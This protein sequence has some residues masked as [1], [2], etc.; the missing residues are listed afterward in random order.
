[1]KSSACARAAA[2]RIC[3]VV[4]SGLPT[5]RFS[6][7]ERLNSSA[8]WNTTPILRRSAASLI[9]RMS[10]PSIVIAPGLRIEGAMQQRQRRRLAGAG[11]ADQ[12]D[13]L[14]RLRDEV[15]I[16]D[17]RRACRR[18]RTR[19]CRTR[20][21]RRRG[22]D[23]RASGRS[24]MRG[25]VSSTSKNSRSR[26]ASMASRLAKPT[27]CSSCDD[28][29]AGERHE[30]DDLADRGQAELE[31]PGAEQDDRQ[32]GER[33]RGA[34]QHRHHRPPR[35]H[36]KLRRQQRSLTDS[37][38]GHFGLDA[39]EALHQRDVA[40]RIGGAFGEVGMICLPRLL[41]SVSVLRSTTAI[42]TENSTHSTSSSMRQPPVDPQRQ[43]Q[44]HDQT[45]RRPR[46]FRGRRRATAPTARRC[47]AA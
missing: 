20:R 43:R 5:R 35:Q 46:G 6:A 22:R 24:C 37:Q 39:G 38:R 44:Q 3:S 4:A 32:H 47:P 14:A 27:A 33:G 1:M 7:I 8:S 17:R 30:G 9:S 18:R 2:S 40:E 21:G 11:G 28:H 42:S 45:T 26:G 10:M 15:E 16:G 25:M 31:Q 34:G 13:G 41:C 12:R 36:R 23:R 19:R 29:H